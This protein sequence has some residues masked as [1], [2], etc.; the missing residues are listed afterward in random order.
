MQ[1]SL[2]KAADYVSQVS[3]TEA[4]VQ[5]WFKQHAKQY[6][7]PEQAQIEYLLLDEAAINKRHPHTEQDVKAWYQQN[8]AHYSQPETRRASHILIL[9]DE[10]ADKATLDA[11]KAKA[12]ALLTEVKAKPES[13]GKF[14]QEKL[15]R[16]GLGRARRRFGLFHPRENG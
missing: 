4:D 11:A 5:A 8:S 2:F 7:A 14:C 12:Q 6:V 10:A 13:F 1:V 16:P 15:A 9:A 3:S